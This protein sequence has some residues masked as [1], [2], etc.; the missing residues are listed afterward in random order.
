MSFGHEELARFLRSERDYKVSTTLTRVRQVVNLHPKLSIEQKTRLNSW[1][2]GYQ[3]D[4]L[5]IPMDSDNHREIDKSS[6]TIQWCEK[7]ADICSNLERNIAG[8]DDGVTDENEF[9]QLFS[10]MLEILG[11]DLSLLGD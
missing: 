5:A 8:N 2:K 9:V 11:F 4:L 6:K 10:N 3:R 7:L 1:L